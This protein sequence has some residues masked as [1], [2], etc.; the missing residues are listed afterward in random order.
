MISVNRKTHLVLIL[1][2]FILSIL[3]CQTQIKPDSK[4]KDVSLKILGT[5]QDGGMPHLGCSKKCCINYYS[6]GF[7][8]KRVVSLGTV[9]YTHLTLPTNREV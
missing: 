4:N 8:K 2:V 3:S 5:V 7:S 9:S 1:G 6:Q